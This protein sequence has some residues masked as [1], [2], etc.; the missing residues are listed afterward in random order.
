MRSGNHASYSY[1]SEVKSE[2]VVHTHTHAAAVP[3]AAVPVATTHHTVAAVPSVHH[4]GYYPAAYSYYS[5]YSYV[6]GK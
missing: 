5:P 3:V 2:P 1:S 4:Y 6:I